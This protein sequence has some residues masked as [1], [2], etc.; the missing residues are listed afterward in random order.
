MG[1]IW[2]AL[3]SIITAVSSVLLLMITKRFGGIEIGAYYA[4]AVAVANVFINV[5]HF[6]V[7]GFQISDVAEKYSFN[8]YLL[9]RRIT[10]LLMGI[11]SFIYVGGKGYEQEK[12]IIIL[13]YCLYRGVYA[14]ADVY[15]GRYQQK[16]YVNIA[17]KLQFFKVLIPDLV[18]TISLIL[19]RNIVIS[20][21]LAI[22]TEILFLFFY[23]KRYFDDF[24]DSSRAS[25]RKSMDLCFQCLPLFFSAFASNYILNSSKYA[26]DAVLSDKMQVYYSVLLL[27]ATT[28]HMIAGFAY[29]PMISEYSF[30]WQQGKIDTFI[31]NVRKILFIIGILTLFVEIMAQPIIIPILE[32]LYAIDDLEEYLCAFQVLLLSGGF[33][34][35]VTFLCY[36]LTIMRLQ[37]KLYWINGIAFLLS[38]YIPMHLV[39]RNSLMGAS[40]SFLILVLVQLTLILLIYEVKIRKR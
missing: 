27:P 17:C 29:R 36:V 40:I 30:I 15:Q 33:N 18:L 14:Y 23:N 19:Y 20:I 10:V 32:W 8:E 7:F 13:L 35:I 31:K 39:R 24:L 25:L 3:S 37:A 5:G 26:I 11:I 34:A 16:G 22:V 28:V 9:L 38:L 2:N 21:I 4:V 1:F 12:G 6:N